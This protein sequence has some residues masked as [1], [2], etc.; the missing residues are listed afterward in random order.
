MG[1]TESKL[2][3]ILKMPM[4]FEVILPMA[5]V[6]LIKKLMDRVEFSDAGNKITMVKKLK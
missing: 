5:G 2:K 3:K 1:K 6:Y 4:K